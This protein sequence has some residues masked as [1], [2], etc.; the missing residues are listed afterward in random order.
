DSFH[1]GESAPLKDSR[2]RAVFKGEDSVLVWAGPGSGKTSVLVA[3]A[4]WL[5]HRQEAEPGQ[6]LLLAF[7]RQ[8]AGE[9]NDRIKERL[10]DVGIQAK[11]FHALALQIIQQGSRKAPAISRLE[12][13]AKARKELLITHWR[14]Q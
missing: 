4:G 6:I 12:T 1:T 2:S 7:G 8:A 3:R 11:T 5:L 9:M 13:D 10:G 14:Q